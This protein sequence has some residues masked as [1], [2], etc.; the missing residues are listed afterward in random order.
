MIA[1]ARRAFVLT[2][3]NVSLEKLGIFVQNQLFSFPLGAALVL[4]LLQFGSSSLGNPRNF[5]SWTQQGLSFRQ[6]KP[7]FPLRNSS[8]CDHLSRFSVQIASRLKTALPHVCWKHFHQ[9][10]PINEWILNLTDDCHTTQDIFREIR[11]SQTLNT[12]SGKMEL[13][14][15]KQL[16]TNYLND[17]KN[18]LRNSNEM[19]RAFSFFMY[20]KKYLGSDFCFRSVELF[21]EES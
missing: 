10:T 20:L 19:P 2:L 8:F 4:S 12:S 5:R 9:W 11:L 21:I 18:V 3:G 16:Y 14:F 1:N 7:Q 17:N 6:G 15:P 13:E